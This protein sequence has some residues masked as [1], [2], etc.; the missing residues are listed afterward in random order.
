M[1]FDR[2]GGVEVEAGGVG[3]GALVGGVGEGAFGNACDGLGGTT[4]ETDTGD[5]P[6]PPPPH[7]RAYNNPTC[8]P[9][10]HTPSSHTAPHPAQ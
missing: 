8:P 2:T 6:P 10:R 5:F 1:S 9:T 3:L 4:G 7:H